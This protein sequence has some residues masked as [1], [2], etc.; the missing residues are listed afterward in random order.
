M[1]LLEK[2][3]EIYIFMKENLKF[4]FQILLRPNNNGL[5]IENSWKLTKEKAVRIW[6]N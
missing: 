5:F 6:Y 4:L 2:N 3:Q 1:N